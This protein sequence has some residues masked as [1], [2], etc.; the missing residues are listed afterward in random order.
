MF[1]LL[2]HFSKRRNI[3]KQFNRF[4][5]NRP[6]NQNKLYNQNNKPYYQN[7]NNDR[8]NNQT[9]L[10]NF[11]LRPRYQSLYNLQNNKQPII[12]NQN[13]RIHNEHKRIHDQPKRIYNLKIARKDLNEV[14]NIK[15]MATI[16]KIITFPA[17]IDLRSK[18]PPIYDQGNLGSCSANALCTA[19]QFDDPKIYPSRLF[20]YY[21]ERMIENSINYD[22][23]AYLSDGVKSMVQYGVCSETDW[24]YVISKFKVKPTTKCYS[25]AL[26]HKVILDYSITPTVSQI[27]QCLVN[28][29][30]VVIGIAVY[31]SFESNAVSSNGM[32]PMPDLINETCLGGHAVVVCGYNDN[33]QWYQ[34]AVTVNLH[35]KATTTQTTS[36]LNKGMWIVRNSW[37]KNWG[38]GGYFYIPYPYLINTDLTSELWTLNKVM[39]T[40]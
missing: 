29:F 38:A 2:G 12:H 7:N 30:P 39:L 40:K 15:L 21:N 6:Y 24:P 14:N 32:L 10:I 19:Y 26:A 5:N 25:N 37:G 36:P 34:N 28:N 31:A 33:L 22:S 16:N 35:G 9:Q 3:T 4:Y 23:G 27:K 18:M 8:Y 20:V 17:I 11:R 13:K 1:Q